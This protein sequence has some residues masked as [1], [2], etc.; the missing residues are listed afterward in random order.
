MSS[1]PLAP[2]DRSHTADSAGQPWAGRSLRANPFAGDAGTPLPA[3]SAALA[4]ADPGERTG[5]VLEALR[6]ERV[7]VP[8]VAHE[9]PGTEEVVGEDGIVRR[10]PTTHASHK[11]GDAQGDACASAA[12]V[13]VATRDGRA[14]LPVFSCV[15]AMRAWN[16]DARPVPVE[17]PRAAQ[18]A[19]VE[20]D[21]LLVL[22]PA[23]ERPVLLGRQAVA[24]LGTGEPWQG[25]WLDRELV[26]HVITLLAPVPG[27]L[28]VRIEAGRDA[29][30]R[31]LLAV[32]GNRAK[33][34]AAVAQAQ[35]LLGADARVAERIDSLELTPVAV[36]EGG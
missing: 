4:L 10:V 3:T 13:S 23:S 18:A 17:S 9:H 5:A 12:M 34:A 24:A 30:A 32:A 19:A 22:D 14:A 7:L 2:K 36:A 35:Q 8:V 21:G 15:E 6:T 11:S 33:A 25:P 26:D 31:I 28:G 27:L 20:T 1:R 16:R 29:E